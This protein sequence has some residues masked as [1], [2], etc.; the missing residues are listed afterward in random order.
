MGLKEIVEVGG[1]YC[2]PY[3][4]YSTYIAYYFN[5]EY[6]SLC[7]LSPYKTYGINP[8]ILFALFCTGG[9][10]SVDAFANG[11]PRCFSE[12]MA[13]MVWGLVPATTLP[14]LP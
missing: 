8:A 12:R 9:D 14:A 13:K 6:M 11:F 3:R 2:V 7:D 5:I 1:R 10:L 4:M